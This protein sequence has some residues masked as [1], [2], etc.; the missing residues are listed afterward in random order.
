MRSIRTL[1]DVEAQLKEFE[2]ALDMLRSSDIDMRK[3]RV[4]NASPSVDPYDY[5]VR[6][7][8]LEQPLVA[9]RT[10]V[11]TGGVS[12][13]SPDFDY[14]VFGLGVNSEITVG[15]DQTPHHIVAAPFT[16]S[17][18]S[19]TLV[20]VYAQAKVP[21]QG[22]DILFSVY[23]NKGVDDV[24]MFDMTI[25][26]NNF[27]VQTLET[28]D[29]THLEDEDFLSIDVLEIGCAFPGS[30]LYVKLKYVWS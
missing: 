20:K 16:S 9:S 4:V 1:L 28:F 29:S 13:P 5:V 27:T 3:R 12:T 15:T 19:A 6:A 26:F 23:K 11:R 17:G 24:K 25:P 2:H 21:S 30:D 10:V 14:C 7:E 22:A 18:H 8:L